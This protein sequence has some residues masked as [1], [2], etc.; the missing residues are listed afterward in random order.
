MLSFFIGARR[1][2]YFLVAL[3]GFMIGAAWVLHAVFTSTNSTAAIGLLFVPVYGGLAAALACALAFVAF[4]LADWRAGHLTEA[5][6]RLMLAAA[7]LAGGGAWGGSYWMY[8]DAMRIASDSSATPQALIEVSKRRV[9]L[10]SED[11]VKALAKNPA[12]PPNL[13]IAIVRA[14]AGHYLVSLVGAN[15]NAPLPLLEEIAGG[16]LGYERVAGL[17]GNPRITP[18]IA[19]RLGSVK[20]ADFRSDIEYKLYQT[21]VLAALVNNPATPQPLFDR[22]AAWE[23]PEHFLAVAVI[24]AGRSTCAQ[25]RRAGGTGSEVLFNTAQSQLRQRGC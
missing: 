23:Q 10:W 1:L 4:T 15:P 24:Y 20:P 17:A 16:P 8:R 25:I 21:F 9:P 18:A 22:L 5:L 14:G 12:T 19:E 2:Q 11:V 13:L 3:A 6:L 7:I